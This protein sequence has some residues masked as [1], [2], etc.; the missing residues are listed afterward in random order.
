MEYSVVVDDAVPTSSNNHICCIV[1]LFVF[2]R[3]ATIR[4]SM[5]SRIL[6]F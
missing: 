2:D 3:V 6:P 1:N 4:I 5:W